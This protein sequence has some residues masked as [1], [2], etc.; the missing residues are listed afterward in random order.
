MASRKATKKLR[1]GQKLESKKNL[2]FLKLK[3]TGN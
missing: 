3:F 1:K 2:E